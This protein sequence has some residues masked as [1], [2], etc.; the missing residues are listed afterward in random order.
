MN[1]KATIFL[2][3]FSL[4]SFEHKAQS[5][6]NNVLGV[7]LCNKQVW[8]NSVTTL[9]A[10]CTCHLKLEPD[11]PFTNCVVY[12]DSC[13]NQN[14]D[15]T[16]IDILVNSDSTMVGYAPWTCANCADGRLYANDSIYLRVYWP[17]PP[18][19]NYWKI[20][21]GFKLYSTVGMVELNK[22]EN[23][24]LISPQPANDIMYIQSTQLHF[25]N[26]PVLYD[27]IGEQ[28]SAE[29]LYINSNTYKVDVSQL[30]AGIYFVF[31]MSDKGYVRKKVVVTH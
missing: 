18:A 5:Y 3:L 31:V 29:I 8:D 19:Y 26:K 17:N 11:N 22:P 30:Q 15:N 20:F 13:F 4:H 2:L 14:W 6:I 28:V 16:P 23:E 9:H 21:R 7:Y 1:K 25:T 10:T 24:L 12:E 27:I